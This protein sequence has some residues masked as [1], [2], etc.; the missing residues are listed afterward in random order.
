MERSTVLSSDGKCER[1]GVY[2]DALICAN[3]DALVCASTFTFC[4]F[5]MLNDV[6]LGLHSC[7]MMAGWMREA[8]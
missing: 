4:Y 6:I 1:V 5:N 2:V 3:V 7:S 8:Q